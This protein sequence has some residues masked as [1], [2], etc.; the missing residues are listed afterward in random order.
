MTEEERNESQASTSAEAVSETETGAGARPE[1]EGGGAPTDEVEALRTQLE[2]AQA[3]AE[4]NWNQLLR[5]RAEMENIRRRSERDV[6]QARRYGVEKFAGELLAVRDSLEMGVNAAQEEGADVEK[7]R[8]G[9]ELTLR[10]LQ[11]AMEKFDIQALEPTG[12]KFDP[13]RHEAMAAQESGE[14]EPNTVLQVVQKGYLLGDRL[15]RPA[16]VIVSR[17]A[18]GGGQGDQVDEQA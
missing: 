13:S 9:S 14:H 5:V 11:Q 4:E 2:E 15:L 18:S 10:M 7:L 6:E 1:S 8:E 12:E 3:K 17:A 16:M